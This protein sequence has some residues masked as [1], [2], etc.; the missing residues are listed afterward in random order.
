VTAEAGGRL[1]FG[2]LAFKVTG[3]ERIHVAGGNGAGKSTLLKLITGERAP[4]SG[5]IRRLDGRIAMLDQHADTLDD[6]RTLLE[7]MRA[8]NPELDDNTAYAALARFAFRNKKALQIV[9]TLSGGERLRLSMSIL[10]ASATPPQLLLLDE[11]TNHLDIDSI[12]VIEKALIAYDGALI[13]VSHDPVFV[14]AIGCS[15]EI[16]L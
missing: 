14:Q 2:P 9:G 15:R 5:S 8:A 7:N 4:A 11:P 3:P 10:L 6:S 1:V 12:E 16:R 13:V